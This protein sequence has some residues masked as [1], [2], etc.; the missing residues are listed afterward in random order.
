[1]NA[2]KKILLIEDNISI[3]ENTKE[4]LEMANFKVFTA[5]NGKS[6][7]Q[8]ALEAPPDLIVCDIVM[9][10][11]DG[12]GVLQL[13]RKNA[14]TRNIPFV[15]LTSKTEK[16]DMRK[17]MDLG[18]DDYLTKPFTGSELLNAIE[19]RL[20]RTEVLKSD[21]KN[22]GEADNDATMPTLLQFTANRSIN[23]YKRKQVIY[24]EGN[25]PGCLFY[26][27]SG[28]VKTFRTN[29]D[30][31]ELILAIHCEGD[32]L[33]YVP[34]IENS[35]YKET[36]EAL[37]ESELAIIP[38]EDFWQ[39]MN[40]NAAISK[41]FISLLAKD[42]TDKE[43]QLLGMAYNSL[44]KKVAEALI[45]VYK[46]YNHN[47]EDHFPIDISRENL[48]SIAATAKESLI[49]TLSDFKNEKLLDINDGIIT[50]LNA[51]KLAAMLN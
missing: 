22:T 42:I 51:K 37:Q 40:T 44:R 31:K 46:K 5:S 38:L 34:L 48:A 43:D 39:L 12:Y 9:P 28:K 30:G 17:G 49:R 15:F 45:T 47:L 32:F 7:V 36:A 29:E 33:G 8:L 18:A 13:L 16:D 26:I 3:L 50:I 41:R 27:V 24:F 1:M 10:L 20:K 23:R 14:G 25:R 21:M 2:M 35:N 4:I 11:L 19:S 6:G